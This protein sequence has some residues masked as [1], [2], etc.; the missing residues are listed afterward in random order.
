VKSLNFK[1]P[2]PADHRQTTPTN[3]Q[4]FLLNTQATRFLSK[5]QNR[6]IQRITMEYDD[7]KVRNKGNLTRKKQ[8]VALRER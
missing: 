1:F 8:P 5:F 7:T 6:F 3:L 2:R 4:Y